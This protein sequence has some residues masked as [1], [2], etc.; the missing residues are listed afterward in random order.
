MKQKRVTPAADD[1]LFA[2]F[3]HIEADN[4]SAAERYYNEALDAFFGL[5]DE[6]VPKRASEKLPEY[7]RAMP[8]PGFK[9]YTL[10]IAVFDESVHLIAALRPGLTNEMMDDKSATGLE[11][12]AGD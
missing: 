3:S 11:E 8:V 1:A 7:V 12:A 9:G 6:L 5:P 4:P 10:R 2:N